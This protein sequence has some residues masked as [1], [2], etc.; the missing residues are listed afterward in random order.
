MVM[1]IK[2]IAADLGLILGL[3]LFLLNAIFY[4][5]DLQLFLNGASLISFVL[6]IGFGIYS[7]INSRKKLGGYISWNDS[8]IS[9]LACV[10]V[11]M[12]IGALSQIFIFVILD[13]VAAEKLHE[14]SMIMVKDMYS[15][16]GVSEE[17]LEQMLI[18]ADK[19]PSFSFSNIILGTFLGL[20]IQVIFGAINALIF[21]RSNPEIA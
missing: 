16:M 12:S 4:I 6:V 10:G 13:P 5:V 18:E 15:S 9:Y 20:L 3:V 2:K 1:D 14:M 17:I 7:I 8:F 19:N 21:K 11:G